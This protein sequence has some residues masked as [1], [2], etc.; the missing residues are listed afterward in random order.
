LYLHGFIVGDD[1]QWVV[2]QQ[3]MNGDSRLARRYHWLSHGLTSFVDAPHSAIDG[4]NQGEIINLTDRRA[5]ASRRHQ[6]DLLQ[7]FGPDGI[8]RE[9]A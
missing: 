1:G 2:V 3:G 8:V 6:L 7:D 9:F 5:A 4:R